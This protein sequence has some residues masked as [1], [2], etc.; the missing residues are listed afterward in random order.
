MPDRKD[1]VPID[2]LAW[3][4]EIDI[5][6]LLSGDSQLIYEYCGKDVLKSLWSNLLSISLY[7]SA[8]PLEDCKRRYIIQSFHGSNHKELAIA[9]GVSERWVYRVLKTIARRGES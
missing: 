1:D 4:D 7:I 9:L 8:K 3:L 5:H 6:D 2:R